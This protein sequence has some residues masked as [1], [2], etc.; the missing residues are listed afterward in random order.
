MASVVDCIRCEQTLFIEEFKTL[1]ESFNILH[2][3]FIL[4][5]RVFFLE[6]SSF[7]KWNSPDKMHLKPRNGHNKTHFIHE[8]LL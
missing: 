8:F 5:A 7:S 6:H 2:M 3:S 4:L 1:Q